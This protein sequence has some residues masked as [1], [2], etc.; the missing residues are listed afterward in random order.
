MVD[1]T[2]LEKL[3]PCGRL[4]TY[5]TARHHLNIFKNVGFSATYITSHVPQ[6]SLR[7]QVYAALRCVITEHVS[8]S[9]IT[10]NEDK[11]Y[12]EAYLARLPEIDLRS[13]VEM[14][15]RQTPFPKDGEMDKEM[16]DVLVEQH[17]CNFKQDLGTKPFWRLVV[18]TSSKDATTFTAIWMWH[19][20][21]ADGA[22]AFLF[23][24]SF[25]AGLNSVK[26]DCEAS[27]VVKSPST[28]LPPPLEGLHRLP[29]TWPFFLKAI[30]GSI[31]PS[32]FAPRPAGLW[33][34]NLVTADVTAL[35][36]PHFRT[37]IF[38]ANTTKTL[39]K[40]SRKERTSVTATLECLLAA[41]LFAN[42]PATECQRVKFE[43]PMSAKRW[44]TIDANQMTNAV[45]QYGYIHSRPALLPERDAS[46]PAVL[47]YFS[48]NEAR[49]VKTEIESELAKAGT[50]NPVALMKYL[51]DMHKYLLKK[52]GK[53]RERSAGLSNVGIWRHKPE[54]DAKWNVGRMTFS[55]S[56]NI[57][58]SALALSV[59]TGGDGNAALNFAWDHGVAD[60][61]VIQK[62]IYGVKEGGH[63]LVKG[64]E[65]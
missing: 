8:L 13:C 63:A 58:T 1:P 52:L 16:D 33:T 47:E 56:P 22:S 60:E 30:L 59:V 18:L 19:H 43:G 35:P 45:A 26:A 40:L 24:E 7:T 55:Q 3:R 53:P 5:S 2:T 57:T 32:I 28:A 36:Q 21:L 61:D 42:L 15:E 20:A 23:H 25:L 41:S 29:I 34:G 37:I 51:P 65:M 9:A 6:I 12:P 38:S 48:W 17:S 44:L 10:L 4:E 14:R 64:V 50:N 46:K 39:A 54:E 27:P 31:L 62:V 49:A 11:S